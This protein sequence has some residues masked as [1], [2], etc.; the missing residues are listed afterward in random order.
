MLLE[1][2][3]F[4]CLTVP[5]HFK[6][7][8][9]DFQ[10][11]EVVAVYGPG[12]PVLWAFSL[13]WISGAGIQNRMT[14]LTE[15]CHLLLLCYYQAGS[16]CSTVDATHEIFCILYFRVK[17]PLLFSSK[18]ENIYSSRTVRHHYN[19]ILASESNGRIASGA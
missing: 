11:E 13:L 16:P 9:C 18:T 12:H 5:L 3:P 2:S 6:G 4:N 8:Q 10:A 14:D 15:P 7:Q 1:T 19:G 17:P